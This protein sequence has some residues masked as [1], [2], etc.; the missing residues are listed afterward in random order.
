M[1]RFAWQ[2][3]QSQYTRWRAARQGLSPGAT[4]CLPASA[5]GCTMKS[6][7]RGHGLAS[8]F[9]DTQFWDNQK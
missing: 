8:Q 1:A 2:V 6:M 3:Q 9:W 7:S 5:G 4:G